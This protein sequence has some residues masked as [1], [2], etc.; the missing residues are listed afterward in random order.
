M[1]PP[2]SRWRDPRDRAH[3]RPVPGGAAVR[4]GEG[5]SRVQG[6]GGTLVSVGAPFRLRHRGGHAPRARRRAGD[7]RDPRRGGAG[8]GQAGE[9]DVLLRGAY[10]NGRLTYL[11]ASGT[12][13]DRSFDVAPSRIEVLRHGSLA[14]VVVVGPL[15]RRTLQACDDL[16]VSVVY[17]TSVRPFDADG[18]V[19][20]VGEDP[21]VIA[22][23]PFVRGDA[24]AALAEALR[25]V[26]SRFVSVGV[27]QQFVTGNQ[28]TRLNTIASWRWMWSRCVAGSSPRWRADHCGPRARS[29]ISAAE[30]LLGFHVVAAD[31]RELAQGPLAGCRWPS[32]L[33]TSA[34]SGAG[35]PQ[36]R[37]AGRARA[38]PRR[39]PRARRQLPAR[40]ELGEDADRPVEVRQRLG[41]LLPLLV[42]P[43]VLGD[44]HGDAEAIADCPRPAAPPADQGGCLV[45]IADVGVH[46][47][48]G[49][50]PHLRQ[51]SPCSRPMWSARATVSVFGL[52]LVHGTHPTNGSV[53]ASAQ[54]SPSR[55]AAAGRRSAVPP[56][57]ACPPRR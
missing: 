17:A 13:N 26:P 27:P 34:S 22:V 21:L 46:R 55:S 53:R 38:W 32:S 14:T 23:E 18:L 9:L 15:L 51:R 43:R 20:V 25:R 8:S 35:R 30:P 48:G 41:E 54:G 45:E 16:D 12:P 6:L 52:F 36:P 24:D 4:A 29:S 2:D 56:P 10:A 7:A 33:Q 3:D 50:R 44:G 1:S 5:R 39:A 19:A 42:Q 31:R 28:H 47:G 40:A 37:R 49:E 57:A 11:R